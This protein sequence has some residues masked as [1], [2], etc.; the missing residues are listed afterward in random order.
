MLFE[1]INIAGIEIKNRMARSAVYEKLADADGNVTEPMLE[2]YKGL[3]VGGVG[4]IVTGN[5]LVHLSGLSVPNALGIYDDSHVDGLKRLSGAVHALDGKIVVQVVHGGRQSVPALLADKTPM[6]PSSVYEPLMQATP[7]EMTQDDIL[8][9]INAFGSAAK[10]ARAAGFD[11]IQIH[12]AHG[13]LVNEFLSPHTNR[14]GDSWGGDVERRANFAVAVFKAMR[15]ASGPDFP[16]LIKINA[17]DCLEG[18]I[19]PHE[20]LYAVKKLEALGL[21]AVEVSGGIY[22]AGVKTARE[23]I[24]KPAD[25]AYFSDAAALFKKELKIPVMVVGG[26]RSRAVMED[27]LKSGRADMVSLARPL[28]RE[29]D[30]PNKFL[31]GKD[32]ADCISCNGCMKFFKLDR[33]RCVQ[34]ARH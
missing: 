9:M 18:G 29:P 6:A 8:K 17:D 11:G 31:E 19:K 32:K 27:V 14:R 22:E 12:G 1:P 5:A 33:V 20:A 28:I 2:L 34:I 26:M 15:E 10:R 25:E 21:A 13:Y 3:A 16:I 23:K 7:R 24:L 30:L 4:L